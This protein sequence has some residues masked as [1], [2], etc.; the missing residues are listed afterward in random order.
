R[1]RPGRTRVVRSC[2]EVLRLGIGLVLIAL[3]SATSDLAA[4]LGAFR[5]LSLPA[6]STP[7]LR[8]PGLQGLARTRGLVRA[9]GETAPTVADSEM[10]LLRVI[11]VDGSQTVFKRA[12]S[13]ELTNGWK[14]TEQV[15]QE[16]GLKFDDYG[17]AY[18]H[19][20]NGV[21]GVENAKDG[22]WFWALY[23]YGSFTNEWIRAPGSVDS[24]DLDTF[25]HIAWVAVRTAAVEKHLEE[26]RVMRFLGPSPMPES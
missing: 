2:G 7:S 21:L 9:L 20:V 8:S 25:P 24:I 18:G 19:V 6:V 1:A 3:A 4:F 23:V 15:L 17:G 13:L 14:L 12:P 10:H 26:E 22:S 5:F 11:K 16:E